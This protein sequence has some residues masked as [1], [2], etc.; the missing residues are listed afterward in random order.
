MVKDLF[1]IVCLI[2]SSSRLFILLNDEE[3][4][5]SVSIMLLFIGFRLFVRFGLGGTD[6][7]RIGLIEFVVRVIWD[8]DEFGK[9]F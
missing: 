9:F 4:V 5:R 1:H 6:A 2:A 3:E 8:N 7:A